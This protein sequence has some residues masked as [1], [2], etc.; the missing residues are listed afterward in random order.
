[1]GQPLIKKR[2]LIALVI[3]KFFKLFKHYGRQKNFTAPW[4]ISS[5]SSSQINLNPTKLLMHYNFH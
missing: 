4:R 5:S 3:S 1:M 2:P